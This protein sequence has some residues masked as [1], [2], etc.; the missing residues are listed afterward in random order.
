MLAHDSYWRS[1]FQLGTVRKAREGRRKRRVTRE[2]GAGL[3]KSLKN[4]NP[5]LT[6]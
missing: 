3:N 6:V 4:W 2:R 1:H 5:T